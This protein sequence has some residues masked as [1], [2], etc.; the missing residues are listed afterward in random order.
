MTHA[1]LCLLHVVD[2]MSLVSGYERHP[3]LANELMPRLRAAGER[4]LAEAKAIAAVSGVVA[5][6]VLIETFAGRLS[7]LVVGQARAWRADLLVIGTHGRRGVGRVL[8]GS[9]AEQIM[10]IA[11]VPVLLV[12]AGAARP[13][14]ADPVAPA[15]VEM[16]AA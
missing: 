10:R 16:A 12:R 13:Q 7:E 11:G 14:C 1:S 5:E 2:E 15:A 6:T 3:V 8:L 4:I 9:D